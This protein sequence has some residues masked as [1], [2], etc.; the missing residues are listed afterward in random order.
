MSAPLNQRVDY[1]TAGIRRAAAE[2]DA[3]LVTLNDL[4]DNLDEIDVEQTALAALIGTPA[5]TDF[6]TDIANVQAEVDK[7]G[8]PAGATFAA[9]VAEIKAVIDEIAN[10][11]PANI[12]TG[13]AILGNT[14][15]Y[16]TEALTPAAAADLLD[17]QVAFVNGAKK[18][19]T[20][21]NNAGTVASVSAAMG[22]GTTLNVVPAEGYT[23]GV[24][25]ITS[26]DLAVVDTD[27]ATGNILA[28][29]TVLGVAGKTEVVDTT[30]AAN[31]AVAGDIALG[32][33]AFVN[34]VKITGSAE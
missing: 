1:I 13:V 5:D 16:D 25:D 2:A 21:P 11:D 7:F 15:T 9:D 30:E 12:K 20:M 19:G 10:L 6:A 29:K 8:T 27:L 3:S 4:E 22:A 34:G 18:V 24:N 33:V 26:V 28:G 17:G 32:K 23:D 31:A 14:G